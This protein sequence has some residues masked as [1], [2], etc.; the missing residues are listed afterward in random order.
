MAM[1]KR[2]ARAI[3]LE[4]SRH[5]R[6]EAAMGRDLTLR[7]WSPKLPAIS[8]TPSSRLDSPLPRSRTGREILP[9]EELYVRKKFPRYIGS[10]PDTGV[11]LPLEV[12]LRRMICT[13]SETP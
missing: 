13:S 6:G 10:A 11:L 8:S 7:R 1:L 12:G 5:R 4:G 3:D 2:R 9:L